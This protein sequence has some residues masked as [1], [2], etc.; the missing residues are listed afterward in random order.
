M[1]CLRANERR[2]EW[3]TFDTPHFAKAGIFCL[4][5]REVDAVNGWLGKDGIHTQ[6]R[7]RN[8]L[9][10]FGLLAGLISG[11]ALGLAMKLLGNLT[12]MA[13]YV[14]LLNVDFMQWLPNPMTELAEFA[15]HLMFALPLGVLFLVLLRIWKSPLGLGLGMSLAIACCTWIPLT[16]LS[17]RVPSSADTTA[18]LWWISGHL[19]YGA[20]LAGFGYLWIKKGW[21]KEWASPYIS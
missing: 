12:G 5:K 16:Q 21:D 6:K 13:V 9:L 17:D 8:P 14:L 4:R 20:V 10:R 7:P 2:M 3:L 15:L 19:I 18:L 11:T 1:K